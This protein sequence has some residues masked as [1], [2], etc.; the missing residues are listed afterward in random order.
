MLHDQC[1]ILCGVVVGCAAVLAGMAGA[2]AFG[3]EATVQVDAAF[4][5]GNILVE[6]TEGDSVFLRQ[7]L[8]DTAGDW[9]YWHFRVRGAAGR[10]LA[11]VFTRG[12]VLG[13]Q[14]PACSTDGGRTWRHLGRAKG[15]PALKGKP[16]FSY[17]FGAEANEVRFCFAIPYLQEDFAALL[18]RH[19][20]RAELRVETLCRTPRGRDVELLRFGAPGGQDRYRCFFTC[21]HHA[22]ESLANYVLEGVFEALLADDDDGRWYRANVTALAV[23]FVD[24]DGVEEGDQGKNRKPHDHNRDYGEG[25]LYPAVAAIKKTVLARAAGGR[26]DLALDLHCP[27]KSDVVIQFVGGQN[28]ELW[29]KALKLA[30]ALEDTKQTALPFAAADAL[31]FGKAWNTN[32]GPQL[33]FGRWAE[34]QPGIRLAATL[35]FPYATVKGKAVSADA[36]R[37]FGRGLARAIRRR[38]EEEAGGPAAPKAPVAE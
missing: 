3:G 13:T 21:R 33:S 23:P 15:D 36:A 28:Q 27:Y 18:K 20:K 30:Q 35:E 9:F 4:P 37:A 12:D 19:E 8:R 32:T 38:L 29:A 26:L 34:Q 10:T 11:F 2:R 24:K 22:C 17:A 31:P 25:G 16:G 7:D 6:K 5:G 14:G 1:A